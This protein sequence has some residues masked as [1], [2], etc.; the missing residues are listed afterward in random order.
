[1][2][3]KMGNQVKIITGKD[4]GKTGEVIE[5]NRKLNLIKVKAIN[6][7]KNTKNQLR[8]IRVVLYPK[9]ALYIIQM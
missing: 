2:N 6:I 9:R 4:K 8:K 5:I 7:V 3:I 1:M